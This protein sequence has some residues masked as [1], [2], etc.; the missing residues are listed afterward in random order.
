M[1]KYKTETCNKKTD[2]YNDS[3][4]KEKYDTND[5]FF[6]FLKPQ[7]ILDV[8]S[9]E[10]HYWS[11]KCECVSNDK[12]T[13]FDA[14]YHYDAFDLLCREYV[15]GS[16]YDLIDLDP[17][18]SAYDCFDL[19]IKMAKKGLIITYGEIGHKRWKRTD[20][21]KYTYGINNIQDFTIENLIKHTQMIAHHNHKELS[22][23][24]ICEWHN[25]A[26]VY[27]TIGDFKIVEQWE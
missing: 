3:H 8:Y 16:K 4:L 19:A 10:K 7:T 13:S 1:C 25:I 26:R 14:T 23:W 24:K 11:N 21:V 6:D 9:G 15:K 12:N 20:F 18:G 17:F 22:V 5:A 2:T 27:Y